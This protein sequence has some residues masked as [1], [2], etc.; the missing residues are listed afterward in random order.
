MC[1]LGEILKE[2][3]VEFLYI[4][5]KKDAVE[6]T[7]IFSF[8]AEEFREKSLDELPKDFSKKKEKWS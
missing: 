2:I 8:L 5:Y 3:A 6:L 4:F 7:E 1:I